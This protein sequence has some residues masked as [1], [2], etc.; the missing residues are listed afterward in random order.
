MRRKKLKNFPWYILFITKEE[1]RHR[2]S[3]RT[4]SFI[5][6]LF[7]R[8]T[9]RHIGISFPKNF[10]L[11]DFDDLTLFK[12]LFFFSFSFFG[13]CRW[14]LKVSNQS[15]YLHRQKACR[16][17]TSCFL[18]V[19]I[20]RRTQYVH[21]VGIVE[22]LGLNSFLQIRE[23][24]GGIDKGNNKAVSAPSPRIIWFQIHFLFLRKQ[25]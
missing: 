24:H 2:L 23:E 22:L 11:F 25:P 1:N 13:I 3:N 6:F 17:D 10:W 5:W 19:T 4:Y 12:L 9:Q 14:L 16:T 7:L 15:I 20:S 8:E 21:I 18:D